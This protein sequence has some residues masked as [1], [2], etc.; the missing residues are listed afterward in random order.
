MDKLSK[1]RRKPK[2]PTIETSVE[3]TSTD[4][5]DSAVSIESP[6][7]AI[8]A[9]GQQK[10][11]VKPPLKKS[12]FRSLRLRGSSKRARGS[13][14]AELSSTPPPAIAVGPDGNAPQN[15]M[16][17]RDSHSSPGDHA[18][19]RIPSFLTLSLQGALCDVTRPS[20]ELNADTSLLLDID[21]KYH[22]LVW[23][24][25]ER[26][27]DGVRNEAVAD[28]KWGVFKQPDIGKKG[29]MDRYMNIKPWNHNRVKLLVPAEEL[30]YVNASTIILNSPSDDS[31][32]PLRYIAMQG[33]TEPS[34]D[35]VWRM[36]AEQL[37]TP[38]VIVQLTT[39]KEGGA[40]KCHQY[41]PLESM[42]ADDPK[43]SVWA[44]N[45]E[46]VWG[47]GWKAHLAFDSIEVLAN[48]AIEKRKLLLSVEGENEPRTI[49]HFLYRRWPDFGVPAIGDIDSFFELMR[50]SREHSN[51][52]T[53]R[54]I[55][56]SAGVGR[57]GTFI[58]LE[59]LIR[60]LDSGAL[61]N[62]D[63]DGEQPDLIFETVELLRQQRRGMV[64]GEIQYQFIYQVLRKLWIKKYGAQES[65]H[66]EPAAKRLEV[67]ESL[68][69]HGPGPDVG[70]EADDDK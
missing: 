44:L 38:A 55:H 48:G 37:Q 23:A 70:M 58:C 26:I 4:T 6:V 65:D 11:S 35:Y 61:E 28:F 64:Q 51:P 12:S 21:C 53:P 2:P 62:Y 8:S 19:R 25:R 68:A 56:C 10:L 39:M 22:E 36:I 31:K 47:D 15:A 1:F 49:W 41:F 17:E 32:P 14:P 33:P 5:A 29:V 30:D 52:S 63:A 7:S 16:G 18:G 66:V 13:P 27:N 9:S 42:E 50:L 3:R 67:E 43:S 45:E 69:D 34:F 40:V 60:E 20:H 54:I 59:H 46:N 24:E 57:T